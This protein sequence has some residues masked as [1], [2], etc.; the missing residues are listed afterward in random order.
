MSKSNII[1]EFWESTYHSISITF[2]CKSTNDLFFIRY[3]NY[4]MIFLNDFMTK[5][6]PSTE[7][8]YIYVIIAFL[9]NKDLQTNIAKY[10]EHMAKND[11]SLNEKYK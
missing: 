6:K 1:Y 10:S 3:P 5:K 9:Y 11:V 7:N 2:L 4:G 8:V